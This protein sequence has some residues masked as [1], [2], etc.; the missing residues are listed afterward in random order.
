[1]LIRVV[2]IFISK[3]WDWIKKHWKITLGVLSGLL[4]FIIGF[5]KGSSGK[6][7]AEKLRKLSEKDKALLDEKNSIIE[8]STTEAIIKNLNKKQE[9]DKKEKEALDNAQKKSHNL[10]E[11]LG[12][13]PDKLDRILIEKH[14]LKKE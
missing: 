4:I 2:M 7:R 14:G 10:K 1:M 8:S 6:E 9:I 5:I 11:E 3:C 12:N 13:N